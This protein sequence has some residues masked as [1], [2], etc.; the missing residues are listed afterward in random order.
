MRMQQRHDRILIDQRTQLAWNMTGFWS[1]QT[2][3]AAG[4][5]SPLNQPLPGGPTRAEGTPRG[6]FAGD[7][8][9]P[10]LRGKVQVE[11]HGLP[12]EARRS[13]PCFVSCISMTTNFDVT[14][15]LPFPRLR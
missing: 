1:F 12:I 4:P 14:P 2:G 7:L 6:R 8:G 9:G 3:S 11:R 10:D 15:P 5:P 13:G